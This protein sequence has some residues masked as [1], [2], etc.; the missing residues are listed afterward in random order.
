MIKL[1]I[2]YT[3]E[4]RSKSPRRREQIVAAA[5]EQFYARGFARVSVDDIA[6]AAGVTK[7]TL[8][9]YFPSKDDLAGAAAEQARALAIAQ[10][11]HWAHTLQD[12]AVLAVPALFDALTRWVQTP[13]W[14]GS[15]FTR[16]A[17][18]LADLPGHPVRKAARTHKHAL[19]D[20]LTIAL[21]D[22]SQA[23]GLALIIEGTLT[24]FLV[25]GDQHVIETG[26]QLALATISPP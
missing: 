20:V 13:R 18:E 14:T 22:R 1:T 4:M 25:T 10:I 12:G 8:Y 7:R 21:G 3:F 24:L 5:Y 19:E 23:R 26:R 15:G 17:M 6:A 16:I 9:S 2:E 11:E